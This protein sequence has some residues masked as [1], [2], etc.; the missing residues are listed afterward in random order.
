MSLNH[1]LDTINEK[2]NQE[3]EKIENNALKERELLLAEAKKSGELAKQ[4]RIQ[5][6]TAK[7]HTEITSA[8]RESISLSQKKIAE[9]KRQ[10]I[11]TVFKR[12]E[13]KLARNDQHLTLLY[14]ALI[15]SL[16]SLKKAEI[17]TT[18]KSAELLEPIL[19]KMNVSFPL[20]STLE[21]EGFVVH[22]ELVEIDNRI[23]VLLEEIR[24]E[25][26]VVVARLLYQKLGRMHADLPNA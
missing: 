8:K 7:I 14:G 16:P 6:L 23:P 1:I 4:K 12:A 13:E 2:S 19:K 18:Q 10:I 21:G 26:Q 5:N 3:I 11:D 15:Q 9:K 24:D 20:K 22:S 17:I 25:A